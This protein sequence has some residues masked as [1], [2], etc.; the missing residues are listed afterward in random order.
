MPWI[1]YS[2]FGQ[3]AFDISGRWH[4]KHDLT[5]A[6]ITTWKAP[7]ESQLPVQIKL[8]R[9][10]KSLPGLTSLA[11]NL[12]Y[13]NSQARAILERFEPDNLRFSPV[14]VHMPDGRRYGSE[15]NLL[16]LLPS[17]RVPG[18]IVIEKSDV[19]LIENFKIPAGGGNFIDGKPYL[20]LKHDP[21]RLTWNRAAV[22]NRHIWADDMLPSRILVSDTL[23]S[24]LKEAGVTGFQAQE[25]RFETEQ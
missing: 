21:P 6:N 4:P 15:I 13:V 16:T 1:L 23:Y 12:I 18:G 10:P 14:I 5:K 22:G 17:C 25:S 11:W 3:D 8:D 9:A 19:R 7:D 2:L 20:R 24:A